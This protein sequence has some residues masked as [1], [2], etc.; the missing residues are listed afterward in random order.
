DKTKIPCIS[1]HANFKGN[2][3]EDCIN[4]K[5][6]LICIDIDRKEN[7]CIDMQMAKELLSKHPST[8]YAGFSV[9]GE[10]NGVFAIM[11]LGHND[12]LINYFNY[13][14]ERFSKIGIN[15]DEKCKDY[16]R[17]R[18]F[19]IDEEAYFNPDAKP[20]T[21]KIEEQQ[22][23]EIKKKVNEPVN[24]FKMMTNAEK[25][26][27]IIEQIEKHNIDITTDYNDWI[28][29]GAALAREFGED[30]RSMYHR[31]SNK[32]TAYKIK[33]CDLKFDSCKRMNKVNLSS[34]FFIASSYGKKY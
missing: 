13:F 15:I 25:V 31:I 16:P 30:G 7:M 10:F 32:H 27:K 1:I 2:R 3:E 22:Q 26:Y 34:L 29:I 5:N 21:I 9:S 33:D 23:E 4:Q 18:F 24:H 8:L 19:N 12:K 28:K 14:K 11:V 20:I 17:V 6:N